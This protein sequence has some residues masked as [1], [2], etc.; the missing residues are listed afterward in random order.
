MDAQLSPARAFLPDTKWKR[1]TSVRRVPR[2]SALQGCTTRRC[3]ARRC[4][5]KLHGLQDLNF[6]EFSPP[7]LTNLL[8]PGLQRRGVFWLGSQQK[9]NV[10]GANRGDPRAAGDPTQVLQAAFGIRLM[11]D[12]RKMLVDQYRAARRPRSLNLIE[13][14][15]F[16]RAFVSS[17][18]RLDLQPVVRIEKDDVPPIESRASK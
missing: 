12:A 7:T 18:L 14:K 17:V 10:G 8:D 13:E 11:T 4:T 1:Q 16:R 9:E 15:V 3:T 5:L 6:L 2:G